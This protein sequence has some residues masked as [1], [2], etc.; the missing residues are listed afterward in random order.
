MKA[1]TITQPWATLVAIGAKQIETRSRATLRRERIAIHAAKGWKNYD[2]E[3]CWEPEFRAA[4]E[5]TKLVDY[6][7]Y[8]DLD[9]DD[10]ER[11]SLPLGAIVATANL[12]GVYATDEIWRW[13]LL[14]ETE[15]A[16]GDYGERRFAWVLEDVT[17]LRE[18]VA[19]KGAL[20]LW[21][22]PDAVEI[23]VKAMTP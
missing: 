17:A 18:P 6:T 16:F 2:R 19:C 20:G 11:F 1:L 10:I 3:A 7:N 13:V 22:V 8:S 15:R 14:S 12:V 5:P 9:I 4:L 21:D 23:I